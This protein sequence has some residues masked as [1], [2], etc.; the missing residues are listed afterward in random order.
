MQRLFSTFANGWPGIALLM[1]RLLV[2]GLLVSDG[3]TNARGPMVFVFLLSR[4]IAAA[5]GLLLVLGLWTPFVG[6]LIALAQLWIIL[7]R[8]GDPRIAV[9]LFVLG[10]TLAMIG[11][12]AWSLDA[13]IFGRKHIG[14]TH[15]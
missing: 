2:G 11:P 15:H 4:G 10:I 6:A 13:R 1:Q 9:V 12:G 3:I 14:I 5:A 8:E 7:N